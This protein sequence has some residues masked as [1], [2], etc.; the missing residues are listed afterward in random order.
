MLDTKDDSYKD[1]VGRELIHWK[2]VLE[3]WQPENVLGRTIHCDDC[4]VPLE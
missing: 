1:W 3:Q 4:C 2:K